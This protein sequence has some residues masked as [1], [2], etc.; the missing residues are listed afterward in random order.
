MA[1]TDD[2]LARLSRLGH[3]KSDRRRAVVEAVCGHEGAF[4]AQEIA[5]ELAPSGIGRATVYRTIGVLQELGY[6]SRLHV[7]AECHRYALCDA[8]HHH[9]MVCTACG[10]VFPF[11]ECG[12]EEQAAATAARIGFSVEGHH[13]DLYGRCAACAGVAA[14]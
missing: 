2:I 12:V 8:T 9:H 5:D 11:E 4:T 10:R 1:L 6:L 13:V 14:D 7:G 3:N